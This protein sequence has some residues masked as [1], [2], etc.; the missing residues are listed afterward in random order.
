MLRVGILGQDTSTATFSHLPEIDL[1]NHVEWRDVDAGTADGYEAEVA[2]TQGWLHDQLWPEIET[3][4]PWRLLC[5]RPSAA[6]V[7]P[8][9]KFV[10]ILFSYHHALTDGTGGKEFHQLLLAALQSQT[11]SS[12]PGGGDTTHRL[13]FPEAP[14]LPESQ[15][16]AIPFT[17]SYLFLLRTFWSMLGPSFL[18]AK[19]TPVWGGIRIDFSLPYR[20]RVKRIDFTAEEVR[21]FIKASR[22]HGATLTTAMHGVILSSLAK[23]IAADEAQSFACHTPISLRPYMKPSVD[24][25]LKAKLRAMVTTHDSDLPK[26]VLAALRAPGADTDAIVWQTG[27]RIRA[28]MKQHLDTLPADD[29]AGLMPLIS[30]HHDYW[31]KKDGTERSATWEIS[32]VGVL[33][34]PSTDLTSGSGSGWKQTRAMF[35]N[36]A[37]VSGAV[38][39]TN[40]ISVEGGI[41][42]VALSWQENAVSEDLINRLAEDLKAFISKTNQPHK[43]V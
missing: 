43:S 12:A 40:V 41:L 5:L 23:R 38:I 26:D 34:S 22:E 4:A 9:D 39:G 28:E 24:S 27:K 13:S 42:T 10:D 33:P 17:K 3:R 32:N 8:G 1:R 29:V 35:T 20:T 19:K 31:R 14:K 18:K 16:D 37:M 6:E 36:G 21:S 2:R 7:V 11:G 25:E 15:E 30:D